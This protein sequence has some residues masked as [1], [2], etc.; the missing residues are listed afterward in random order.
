[1]LFTL[2][3]KLKLVNFTANCDKSLP[4]LYIYVMF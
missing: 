3:V 2:S 1:M 4:E